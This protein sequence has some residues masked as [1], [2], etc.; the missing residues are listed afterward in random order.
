M[1]KPIDICSNPNCE[2]SIYKGDNVWRR[3]RDLFCHIQC[4]FEVMKSENERE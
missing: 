2:W 4:L 3:G 1:D